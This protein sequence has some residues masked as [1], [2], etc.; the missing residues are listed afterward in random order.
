[1]SSRRSPAAGLRPKYCFHISSSCGLESVGSS[2][3]FF[4]ISSKRTSLIGKD[5][6]A[7]LRHSVKRTLLRFGTFRGVALEAGEHSCKGD[8]EGFGYQRK[9][10]DGD[11]A[12]SALDIGQKAAI[13]ARPFGQFSLGPASFPAQTADSLAKAD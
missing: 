7:L 10:E 3:S 11:V 4:S 12:L 5:S 2:F 6:S 9:I 1:M 8:A 13:N